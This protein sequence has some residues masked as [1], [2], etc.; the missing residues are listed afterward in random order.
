MANALEQ[1]S[2]YPETLLNGMLCEPSDRRWW[3]LYTKVNQEKAIA[4]HLFGRQIP[5]YLPMAPKQGV[6]RA[7]PTLSQAPVFAG[8]VFLFGN[9]EERVASLTTNRVSRVLAV[10]DEDRLSHD[11]RQLH[12][13]ISSG[14]PLTVERR[15]APGDRVRVRVGPLMG[16]EGTVLRR[17]GSTR[18][19]V[20]IDFLQQGASVDI[21]DS[22]L[23]RVP[24]GD[25]GTGRKTSSTLFSASD[26]V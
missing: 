26:S 16:L 25:A 17:H 21:D 15:L 10:D 22:L 14:V 2:L 8:Y 12:R 13:M 20:A 18:L 5:F 3:V 7:R 9:E 24:L 6:A 23:E 11:L 4:R 19:L 1:P